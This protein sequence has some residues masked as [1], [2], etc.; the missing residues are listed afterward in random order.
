MQTKDKLDISYGIY[1]YH[2][3]AGELGQKIG[4]LAVIK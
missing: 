4:K 3:D 1:V 2:I